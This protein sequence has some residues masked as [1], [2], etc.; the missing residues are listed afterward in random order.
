MFK[1]ASFYVNGPARLLMAAIIAEE[2]YP[3]E[4]KTLI[5]LDQFGYDYN[6]LLPHVESLFDRIVF[7]KGYERRYS[8]LAQFVGTYG[9]RYTELSNVFGS[10]EH[11]V[12]F[13]LRSPIQKHIIQKNRELGNT[14]DIFAESIA[15]DRYF[16]N[17]FDTETLPRKMARRLMARAFDYQ[18]DYDRFFMHVPELYSDSPHAPKFR[19]MPQ[20]FQTPAAAKYA[21]ILLHGID[22]SALE[23]Y[24]TV[25]FGQPL[26]NHERFMSPAQ[27]EEIL[28][29]IVGDRKVLVMP[30]PNERLEPRNKYD[31]LP[32][33]YVVP[34]G[35]PNFLICQR[36][37]LRHTITYSSTIGIDYA[38]S[39][40]NS[41]NLFYPVMTNALNVLKQYA[42]HVPNIKVKDS[43]AGL[44]SI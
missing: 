23:G 13:G 17:G 6:G 19:K 39:R 32:N 14:I 4:P 5:L 2:Y 41:E 26:S 43:F 44:G 10:D 11:A 15:V 16:D 42:R 27:E 40:P 18:H 30:H 22:L 12:L 31:V 8:H 33:A 21:E 20:L 38:L 37:E 1:S 34:A 25:F 24:D 29:Q 9:R 36:L 3:D 7:I 28:R 35:M